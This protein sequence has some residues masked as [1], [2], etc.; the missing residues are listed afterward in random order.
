MRGRRARHEQNMRAIINQSI[1]QPIL[2]LIRNVRAEDD[3]HDI[4]LTKALVYSGN[5][6]L[7][8]DNSSLDF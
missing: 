1:N 3:T 8:F 6:Q 7:L 4:I 2:L 5:K